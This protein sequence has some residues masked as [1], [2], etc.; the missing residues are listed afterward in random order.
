MSAGGVV[1]KVGSHVDGSG[2]WCRHW[3]PMMVLQGVS[4]KSPVPQQQQSQAC[5]REWSMPC[6]KL[7]AYD[8]SSIFHKRSTVEATQMS[9]AE[10]CMCSVQLARHWTGTGDEK[11]KCGKLLH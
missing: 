10:E 4:D 5:S 6:K 8:H 9:T 3:E 11:R 2:G 7:A 1:G